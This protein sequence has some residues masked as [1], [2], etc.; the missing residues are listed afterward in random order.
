VLLFKGASKERLERHVSRI[1]WKLKPFGCDEC[2]YKTAHK[3][4]LAV[5]KK[6]KHLKVRV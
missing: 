2:E 4:S 1:H 3:G 5:H 6:K